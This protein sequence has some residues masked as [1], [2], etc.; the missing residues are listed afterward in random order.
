MNSSST[1]TPAPTT[2]TPGSHTPLLSHLPLSVLDRAP[3]GFLIVN[4]AGQIVLVNQHLL[5]IFKH[6]SNDFLGQPVEVLLP[7]NIRHHHPEMMRKYFLS[8]EVRPMGPGRDLFA[9]RKDGTTFPVEIGLA[10]I[11]LNGETHV[12]ATISDISERKAAEQKLRCANESLQ[13]FVY[14]ASHDLRSPLRGIADLLN[15]VVD[16]LGA[17]VKP[18]V[19]YNLDRIALRINRLETLISDLLS[20]S[21]A[22][23]VDSDISKVNL[24]DL[25]NRILELQAIPPEFKIALD[26]PNLSI[27][28]S[29]TPLETVLR[30]LIANAVKHH[31]KETGLIKIQ[32]KA[33]IHCTHFTVSDDGPGIPEKYQERIFKLFQTATNSE[34]RGTGLGLSISRRMIEAHGGTIQLKSKDGERGASFSFT[35]PNQ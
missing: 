21:R 11:E 22:G 33:G 17:E 3:T 24:P 20:Y 29:R 26:V 5:T 7:E 2:A 27:R 4:G 10:P 28:A 16:D 23:A 18:E 14:V 30:N 8:P 31:D 6:E 1:S 15:W 34:R 32:A 35:W 13:E 9:A 12:L 19:S 25:L